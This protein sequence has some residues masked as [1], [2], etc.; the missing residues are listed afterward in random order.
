MK[1][2]ATMATMAIPTS[3]GRRTAD[4]SSLDDSA[5]PTGRP[6]SS[7]RDG[8]RREDGAH[9]CA[10]IFGIFAQSSKQWAALRDLRTAS[11]VERPAERAGL[12]ELSRRK[13]SER[14]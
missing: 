6:G 7:D 2:M 9:G 3:T 8:I 1:C 5:V 11:I 10:A 13:R 12:G 14:L 4:R